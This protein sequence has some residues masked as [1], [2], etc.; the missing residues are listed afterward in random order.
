MTKQDLKILLNNYQWT[1]KGVLIQ[2]KDK[3]RMYKRFIQRAI[4]DKHV[5]I[6]K[7]VGYIT[8]SM[9]ARTKDQGAIG[10]YTFPLREKWVSSEAYISR[11][12]NCC[13]SNMTITNTLKHFIF[14]TDSEL[15]VGF[16]PQP[17]AGPFSIVGEFVPAYQEREHPERIKDIHAVAYTFRYTKERNNKITQDQILS[18]TDDFTL[19]HCLQNESTYKFCICLHEGTGDYEAGEYAGKCLY[20]KIHL[21]M[22]TPIPVPSE[23]TLSPFV[24]VPNVSVD[25]GLVKYHLMHGMT[26]DYLKERFKRILEL[27]GDSSWYQN[28]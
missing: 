28:L 18:D 2:D 26:A 15:L 4:L 8:H 21:Q 22:N 14:K 13:E 11:D 12:P 1:P 9:N 19:C 20:K 27:G 24:L 23:F 7:A 5:P 25:D 16:H 6:T 3:A 17:V 10:K